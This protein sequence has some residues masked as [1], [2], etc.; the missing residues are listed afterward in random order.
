MKRTLGDIICDNTEI[1]ETQQEVM[2]LPSGTNP[3][4][5]CHGKT[6]LDIICIADDII[7][8]KNGKAMTMNNKNKLQRSLRMFEK[9]DRS[10]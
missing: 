9:R 5:S 3:L 4:R 8:G 1:E 6:S 10:A 7:R 2:R